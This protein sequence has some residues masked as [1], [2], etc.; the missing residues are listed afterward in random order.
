MIYGICRYLTDR[1]LDED[2]GVL[3]V[4][5]TIGLV[6]QM[7]NDFKD[8]SSLNGWGV[9]GMV[10]MS[11]DKKGGIKTI[12]VTTWQSIF[13]LPPEWF[14]RF[15]ALIVDEAHQA[16][17]ASLVQIGKTCNASFRYGFSGSIDS[18]DET[19]EMTLRGLFGFKYVATTTKDLM[20]R[21]E[22]ATAT[23]HCVHLTY[24]YPYNIPSKDY[25]KEIEWM[26]SQQPRNRFL[27]DL[28][29]NADGNVLILFSLVEKHGKVLKEM[30]KGLKK[31]VFFV[32]GGVDVDERE[33]IRKLAETHKGCIILASYQTFSTGISI[34]NLHHIMFGSPT[35][36]FSRVVQSIGRGLRTSKT[37]TECTIWDLFDEIYGDG[38][39]PSSYNYTFKHFL[40]RAKIYIKEGF[41]YNIEKVGLTK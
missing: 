9:E 8:Y 38:A 6:T 32:Y 16:K 25:Q 22:V 39:N 2:K 29:D 19:T 28:A 40:E 31:E 1:V 33:R 20:D 36:S 34:R 21:K 13:R 41:K 4:V 37:K 18:E 15:D 11:T 5:P 10:S 26:V 30:A 35:K 3:I 17:A 23:V 24:D 14:E 7:V 12:H 27:L